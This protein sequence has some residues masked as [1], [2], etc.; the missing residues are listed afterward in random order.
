MIEALFDRLVD[1][2]SDVLPDFGAR[3][4]VDSKAPADN[5]SITQFGAY[6]AIVR[7]SSSRPFSRLLVEDEPR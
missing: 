7:S 4:A 6:A 5:T 3:L 1:A 2:M